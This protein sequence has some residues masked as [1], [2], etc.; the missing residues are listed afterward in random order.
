MQE[1]QDKSIEYKS[2]KLRTFETGDKV[3]VQDYRSG[4]ERWK[5]A[6]VT[7]GGPMSYQV[8]VP[9]EGS[10]WKRHIDQMLPRV[11]DRYTPAML[12]SE[13]TDVNSG[14]VPDEASDKEQS[15]KAPIKEDNRVHKSKQETPPR[16]SSR[17]I[18]KPKRLIKE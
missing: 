4:S 1:N 15:P 14:S 11:V 9:S 17:S 3:L 6:I 7:A 13:T 5:D 2:S 8:Q 10:I 12:P 18:I 16:R